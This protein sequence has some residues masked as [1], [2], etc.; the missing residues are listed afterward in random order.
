MTAEPENEPT[1]GMPASPAPKPK[2]GRAGAGRG[3]ERRQAR[4]LALQAFFEADLT[5]HQLSAIIQ[6]TMREEAVVGET[7]GYFRLLTAGIVDQQEQI[8]ELIA[9]AA[10]AFPIAQLSPVDRN[11][12]RIAV[13]ELLHPDQVPTRAAINEAVELA[14]R[15]GGE[16]SS[17]FVNGVL[18][19]IAGSLPG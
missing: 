19:T 15:F 13:W 18:A 10:P 5:S 6:R 16:N 3:S 7:E 2:R 12:L 11:V 4:I 14:K 1:A 9:A 8:D 17:R